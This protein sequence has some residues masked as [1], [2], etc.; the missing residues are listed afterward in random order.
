[1][2]TPEQ[3]YALYVAGTLL[4]IAVIYLTFVA[5]RYVSRQKSHYV[6]HLDT[7]VSA[8][9]M[10]ADNIDNRID[11]MIVRKGLDLTC[12][13]P[14]PFLSGKCVDRSLP[15]IHDKLFKGSKLVAVILDEV[16]IY[17]PS[18]GCLAQ[19]VAVVPMYHHQQALAAILQP[20]NHIPY[21][22]DEIVI[23]GKHD[24]Y[25]F[26][27]ILK[28]IGSCQSLNT[29]EQHRE[30]LREVFIAIYTLRKHFRSTHRLLYVPGNTVPH[31]QLE[32]SV[33]DIRELERDL[34]P[35]YASQG[36]SFVIDRN[37]TKTTKASVTITFSQNKHAQRFAS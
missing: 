5:Y 20:V 25:V 22:R 29:V 21:S 27:W 24:M 34:N 13:Y 32:I 10:D 6:Y 7:R 4:S 33:W 35:L 3:M 18:T 26:R 19:Y 23:R 28:G 8:F 31:V 9:H 2:N 12:F 30:F 1:M 36:M 37:R 14:T 17:S 15:I 16:P 11:T